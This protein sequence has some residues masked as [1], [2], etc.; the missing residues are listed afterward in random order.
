MW[1][2]FSSTISIYN[3]IEFPVAAEKKV[4]S[5]DLITPIFPAKTK[6]VDGGVIGELPLTSGNVLVGLQGY[7]ILILDPNRFDL[8]VGS[9]QRLFSWTRTTL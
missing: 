5:Q 3:E 1:S 9:R 4:N 8:T 2:P 6:R 7:Y